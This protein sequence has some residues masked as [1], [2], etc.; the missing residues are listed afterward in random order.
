VIERIPPHH[1]D[2]EAAIIGCALVDAESD[3][4]AVERLTPADFYRANHAAPRTP[5]NRRS[6]ERAPRTPTP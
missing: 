6:M 3:R 5:S 4:L 2:G 1:D